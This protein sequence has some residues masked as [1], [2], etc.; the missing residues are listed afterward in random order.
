MITADILTWLWVISILAYIFVYLYLFLNKHQQ[1]RKAL[2]GLLL[3]SIVGFAAL[4][5]ATYVQIQ[6]IDVF[7]TDAFALFLL[8]FFIVQ[9]I[10]QWAF[11]QQR[12]HTPTVLKIY[13]GFVVVYALFMLGAF[14]FHW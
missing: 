2:L 4:V 9:L 5:G 7:K 11:T 13:T 12:L 10:P 8:A 14:I 3:M 6:A 1:N